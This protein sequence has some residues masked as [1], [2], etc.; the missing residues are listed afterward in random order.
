FFFLY[1]CFVF[2]P[3][4]LNFSLFFYFVSLS[5]LHIPKMEC[6]LTI[7]IVLKG[8]MWVGTMKFELV[9]NGEAI[10]VGCNWVEGDEEVK[11]E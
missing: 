9:V 2:W 10:R 4:L 3:H 11:K 8:C 1:F 6:T 5:H 7:K